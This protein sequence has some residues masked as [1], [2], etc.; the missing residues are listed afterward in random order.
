MYKGKK[1]KR[2]IWIIIVIAVLINAG[3]FGFFYYAFSKTK[4]RITVEAG[5]TVSAEDFAAREVKEIS[6]AEGETIPDT[7]K[8]GEFPVKIKADGFTRK[9]TLEVIDTTLP[10]AVGKDTVVMPGESVEAKDMLSEIYDETP[11]TVAFVNEP[12]FDTFGEQNVDIAVT[13]MAGNRTVVFTRLIVSKVDL[14][15]PYTL[16]AGEEIPEASF[17]LKSDGQCEY[18]E[19]GFDGVDLNHVGIYPVELLVDGEAQEVNLMIV[20]TTAPVAQG[21]DRIAALGSGAVPESFVTDVVDATN[22]SFEFD[23]EPDWSAEGETEVTVLIIDEGGNTTTVSAHATV[24]EDTEA[25]V[26]MGIG[27]LSVTVGNSVSYRSGVTAIDNCDGEVEYTIDNSAVDISVVGTYPVTYTAVDASG[28]ESCV[29]VTISIMEQK[30]EAV[31]SEEMYAIADEILAEILTDGMTQY[32][33]AQAIFTWVRSHIGWTDH[34]EKDDWIKS[35]YDGFTQ[36]KGD[37]YTFAS[38]SKAL[39]TRAGIPNIDCKRNSVLSFHIWNLVDC[40]DGWYHFDAT[41]R[42]DKEVIFMW[43]ENELLN[44]E[45]VRRSHVYD[46]SLYPI[47]NAD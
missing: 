46:R 17:F 14:L 16:E 15:N 12:D 44:N 38:A 47:V 30:A 36:H 35:A 5:S 41:P 6:F 23:G 11:V 9:C 25:P 37:C 18:A 21:L 2:K 33:Q 10:T 24:I 34:T 8:I 26:F 7:H 20:D 29:N 32:E 40:G 39:L 1:M 45:G 43:S 28:N 42:T 31:T 27:D 4:G 19:G 3:V 22:C 13:D